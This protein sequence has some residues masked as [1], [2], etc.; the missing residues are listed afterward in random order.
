MID[1]DFIR[2]LRET[3]ATVKQEAELSEWNSLQRSICPSLLGQAKLGLCRANFRV[4]YKANAEKLASTLR[5]AGFT[6][7]TMEVKDDSSFLVTI[8]W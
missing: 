1:P 5:E 3:S 4:T 7:V 8:A 2:R 6:A